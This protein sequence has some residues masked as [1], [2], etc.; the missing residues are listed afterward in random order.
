M[1]GQAAFTQ[2][3]TLRNHIDTFLNR[4]EPSLGNPVRI[5]FACLKVNIP[6]AAHCQA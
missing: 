1:T 2:N 3:T 5:R 6:P 4:P